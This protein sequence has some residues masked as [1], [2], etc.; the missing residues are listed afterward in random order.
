VQVGEHGSGDEGFDVACL[1]LGTA[2]HL[3]E[4]DDAISCLQGREIPWL[5]WSA[6]LPDPG[7]III[8]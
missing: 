3:L 5:Y 8:F 1:L 2:A 4:T 6:T 7:K